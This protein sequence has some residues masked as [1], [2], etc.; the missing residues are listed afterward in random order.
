MF[1]QEKTSDA[2]QKSEMEENVEAQVYI[3]NAF[4]HSIKSSI[5]ILFI[6]EQRQKYLPLW[7]LHFSGEIEISNK[8]H[9]NR[10]LF[11]H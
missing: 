8:K 6:S 11:V 10:K 4:L 3:I 1:S 2:C 5:C 9:N 7:R